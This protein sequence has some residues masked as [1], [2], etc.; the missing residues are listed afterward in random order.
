MTR[1]ILQFGT[2]RFLQAHA[3]LFVHEARQAGQNIGPITIVK[4]TQ[5]GARDGRVRAFGG[6]AGYPV[7]IRGFDKGR[8]VDETRPVTSVIRALDAH[9]DWFELIEIF[10]NSTEIVVS[11]TGDNGY[12]LDPEDAKRRPAA[13]EVPRSFPAKLLALLISR[14]ERG[15]APLLVLP[16]ELVSR[17]GLALRGLLGELVDHWGEGADFKLWLAREVTICDTLVDRIVSEAIEPIGAVAEPYALWAIQRERGLAEPLKHPDVVYTDDLEPY[18]RL[19]LHILNLS[20]SYLADI[21]RREERRAEETVREIIA[22]ANV[23]ARIL[24][25]FDD[26]ILPG[27]AARG[28]GPQAQAY[29]VSTLERFEN[30]FLNHKISDI[31]EGHRM[32]VERRAKA[33]VAWVHAIDPTLRLPRLEAFTKATLTHP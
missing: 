17:N 1:R 29:L 27:F 23:R 9:A 32:K 7:R 26:E 33:F 18:L 25:L 3:D 5:G 19:K 20:H 12:G 8:L 30:P 24:S 22:D 13:G 4:T 28:L 21:W 10:S 6:A 11:N 15:A 14:F 31:F 16:C 2:S